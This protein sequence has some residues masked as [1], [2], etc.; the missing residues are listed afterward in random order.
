MLKPAAD[1]AEGFLADAQIGGDETK[2]YPFN[3]VRRLL[4]QFFI[5]LCCCFKLSVHVSFF[6]PDIIS[7]I[8]NPYQ[9]FNIVV[10]I[11]KAGERFFWNGPKRAAFHKL[12]VFNSR[13]AGYETMKGCNKIIFKSK[14]MGYLF[15]IKVVKPAE[16]TF[17]EE[18]QMPANISLG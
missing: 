16:G 2:R 14:P 17:F 11:K 5:P 1:T 4:F 6:E 7:F 3:N 12:N 10:L 18:I 15:S 13:L 8:H 9:S